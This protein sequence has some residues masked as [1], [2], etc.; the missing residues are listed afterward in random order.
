VTS[1]SDTEFKSGGIFWGGAGHYYRVGV[2]LLWRTILAAQATHVVSMRSWNNRNSLP[3]GSFWQKMERCELGLLDSRT[4]P[5]N[6]HTMRTAQIIHVS[7]C[8]IPDEGY[9]VDTDVTSRGVLK[10]VAIHE[11]SALDITTCVSKHRHE[12]NRGTLQWLAWGLDCVVAHSVWSCFSPSTIHPHVV[13]TSQSLSATQKYGRRFGMWELVSEGF[14]RIPPWRISFS[15]VLVYAGRGS[16]DPLEIT[17][18]LAGCIVGL[19]QRLPGSSMALENCLGVGLIRALNIRLRVLYMIAPLS[20][21]LLAVVDC[22]IIRDMSLP[23]SFKNAD[24]LSSS[25]PYLCSNS[26]APEG[27]GARA[28]RSRNNIMRISLQG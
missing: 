14:A 23:P 2:E 11:T 16:L 10:T 12:S 7:Q 15:D 21:S 19:A 8:I 24:A 22:L 17:G 28:I 6:T 26:L 9:V 5:Y 20:Y 13:S 4:N 1:H 18:S 27:T 25:S 3:S